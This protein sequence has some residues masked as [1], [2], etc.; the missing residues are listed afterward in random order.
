M[1]LLSSSVIAELDKRKQLR[2]TKAALTSSPGL[3]RRPLHQSPTSQHKSTQPTPAEL[4]QVTIINLV[5]D[6]FQGAKFFDVYHI[7]GKL[8]EF[9][10][11]KHLAKKV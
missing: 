5:V 10:L 1:A 7:T 9:A 6:H 4:K 11:F 8:G 2:D 3:A